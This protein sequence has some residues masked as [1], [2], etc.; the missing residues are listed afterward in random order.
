MTARLFMVGALTLC[1]L[2]PAHAVAPDE[3]EHQRAHYPRRWDD[4]SREKPLFTCHTKGNH[5]Q[6]RIGITD[7]AGRTLMSLV[8]MTWDGRRMHDRKGV[9][10]IWLDREQMQRLREGKYFATVLRREKA[11]WIRGSLD[12]SAVF[13]M[14]NAK[15][16]PDGPDAGS[17]YNKTP[18]FSV[19]ADEPY[20]CL[21]ATAPDAGL[22]R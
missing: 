10:R 3:C 20:E 6:I 12:E 19:F 7:R 4:T 17:F 22:P 9:Y 14:D 18:R 21:P 11:C 8:Q 13:F 15:P 2:W 1:L 5:L 16:P